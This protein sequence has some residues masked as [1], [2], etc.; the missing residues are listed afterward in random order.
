MK[1]SSVLPEDHR[2][3]LSQ[4]ANSQTAPIRD[5]R[6]ALIV[7]VYADTGCVA[8]AARQAGVCATTAAT[9]IG[10]YGAGGLDGLSDLPR[11]GAPPKHGP[12]VILACS[13][14]ATSAAPAPYTVWTFERLAAAL[15]E[16]GHRVSPDWCR[17]TLADLDLNPTKT[18]GWLNRPTDPD[19][20]AEFAQRA[21]DV[22]KTLTAVAKPATVRVCLDEKTAI[23]ARS[24]TCADRPAIP[25]FRVKREFEYV[26]HGV[27]NLQGAYNH[28]TG[29]VAARFTESN[30][31]EAFITFVS[32][33]LA[34]WAPDPAV[35]V[36]LVL[37]N[38]SSHT[39][40]QAR[41]YLAN[42]PQIR[43]HYTPKHA[44]WLNPVRACVLRTA[45][46]GPRR[47]FVGLP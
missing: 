22:C 1:T 7:L 14:A 46:T 24:R 39:S 19:A 31:T 20:V 16:Q 15:A 12:D 3:H 4:I 34:L 13:A 5:V 30:N 8:S 44:S 47:R 29:Q 18:T 36:E 25:G 38:G 6:R 28:D 37:D 9:W 17:T 11:S 35:T 43:V 33:L 26:R 41:A 27:V 42:H 21:A 32:D 10:R 40:K 45:T 2:A 23:Q